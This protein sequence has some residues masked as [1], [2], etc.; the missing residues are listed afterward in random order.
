MGFL[1]NIFNGRDEI[2]WFII[3]FLLLFYNPNYGYGYRASTAA[4]K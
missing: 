2:L 1:G 3:L 4:E